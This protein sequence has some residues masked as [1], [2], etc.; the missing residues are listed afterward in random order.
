[1]MTIDESMCE[2]ISFD[3]LKKQTVMS[4]SNNDH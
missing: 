3:M 4:E 1:M 2:R